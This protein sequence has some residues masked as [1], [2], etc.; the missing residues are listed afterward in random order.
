MNQLCANCNCGQEDGV[1]W[2]PY[3][4]C[5]VCYFQPEI[6]RK[7]R[8]GT[9]EEKKVQ[10]ELPVEYRLKWPLSVGDKVDTPITA[11]EFTG[12]YLK[13]TEPAYCRTTLEEFCDGLESAI[14]ADKYKAV[15][16]HEK[17]LD[18]L[19]LAL[20]LRSFSDAQLILALNY[21]KSDCSD[22]FKKIMEGVFTPKA[23]AFT[24]ST[25]QSYIGDYSAAQINAGY[26]L[27]TFSDTNPII[28]FTPTSTSQQKTLE[29][30][31]N[32]Y[33]EEQTQ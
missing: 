33:S 3:G 30:L 7:F 2:Y 12:S 25:V 15:F 16:P 9:N 11:S 8:Q 28:S 1:K 23:V 22:R 10:E 31:F 6:A 20:Y 27:K 26:G 17:T 29:E 13:S 5:K 19:D 24:K 18:C 21:I 14:S 4:L 32:K